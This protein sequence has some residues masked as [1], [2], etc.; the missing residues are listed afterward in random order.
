ML[1][2]KVVLTCEAVDEILKCDSQNDIENKYF[3]LV[4]S[5][6]YEMV[7]NMC[8]LRRTLN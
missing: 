5:Q 6:L 4:L 7:D 3:P 8:I 2:Y 1:L